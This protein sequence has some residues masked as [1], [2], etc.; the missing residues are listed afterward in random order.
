MRWHETNVVIGSYKYVIPSTFE[1]ESLDKV[2][3]LL[4]MLVN[5]IFVA[6]S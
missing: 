1:I 6:L 2:A 3:Y 5:N 4:G